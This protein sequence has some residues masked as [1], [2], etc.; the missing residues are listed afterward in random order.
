MIK[1]RVPATSANLGP[2]F[3]CMGLALDIWNEITFEPAERI[4]YHVEGE[5]AQKFNKGSRNLLTKAFLRLHEVCGK[6]AGGVDI[7]S[8]NE[9]FVSSGLGSS[10][11]AIVGGLFGANEIL[12]NPLDVNEL[13]VIATEMEGHP[14]NAAPALFGGLVV[15]I[16]KQAHIITRRYDVPEMMILIVTPQVEW[17]TKTARAV[18]P[19]SFSR[20]DALFNIGRAAL[21][22]DALRSGDLNLLQKVMDDRIHQPYR[23]KHINGGTAAIKA[24]R[25]LGAAALSG[26]GPSI[27]AFIPP[28]NAEHART[29][30]CNGFEERGVE[31]RSLTTNPSNS[32]TQRI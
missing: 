4:T 10:A 20:S 28:E 22:V 3:D 29:E 8:R 31:T 12:G 25:Q 27:I 11:A 26:A 16:V 23:L 1:I 6:R 2:G 5:G 15:S 24:A 9:I 19:K 32:G 18:L 30:I 14:D 21:V 13:L 7:K 17:L